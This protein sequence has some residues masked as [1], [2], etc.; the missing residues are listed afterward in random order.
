[1]TAR[2]DGD[3]KGLLRRAERFAMEITIHYREEGSTRWREGTTMNISAS[4]ML[5]QPEQPVRPRAILDIAFALPVAV[6]GE[7]PA[8][9][10]CRGT[11]IREAHD[12]RPEER[13]VAAVSITSY[14]IVK[15]RRTVAAKD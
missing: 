6:R 10:N 3:N 15:K 9:V 7:E 12:S 11:V 13:P 14:R 4:G 1:V 8:E 2:Q 5:F